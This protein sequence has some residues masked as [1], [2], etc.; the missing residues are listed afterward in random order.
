MRFTVMA[1]L[2]ATVPG[3][4]RP[5]AVGLLLVLAATALAGCGAS[6]GAGGDEISLTVTRDYGRTPVAALD[7]E[8]VPAPALERILRRYVTPRGAESLFVNGIRAAAGAQAR[9]HGGDRV[10]LD[11]HP[12]G[13]APQIPAVV[14]S[15]PEPFVHGTDG[16]RLP[17]R[18]ECAQ[19]RGASCA[20]VA[21]K[22]VGLGVVAGRSV[23][24]RSAADD[25]LRIL[26]APW[27][28]LR[29]REL[30]TD[31]L[32]RGPRSS[33]VYARFDA[34]GERLHVLDAAGRVARTLGAGTGL[35]AATRER[36][37]R[38]VW[39]V[40][41]TDDAGVAAAARALDES[42]LNDRFALAISDDLPVAVPQPRPAAD[43]AIR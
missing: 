41:G 25:T 2:N 17:V 40:T 33:G 24:G 3:M 43:P 1:Q 7:R 21:D 9:V 19:P 4:S 34:D 39:F 10:W 12:P 13:V 28:R 37:R 15:F 29:G 32:D 18:I 20:A 5:P 36:E 6:A 23:L 27:K 26:V 14:G 38:P 16:K 42:A 22:L 30:E 8:P 35:I 11:Q 31:S